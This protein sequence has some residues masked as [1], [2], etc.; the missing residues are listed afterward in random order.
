MHN[1]DI[2]HLYSLALG[3]DVGTQQFGQFGINSIRM[4][5]S[6]G[7]A[8][9]A[10]KSGQIC[11]DLSKLI[12]EE[13]DKTKLKI[14]SDIK[15]VVA[16]PILDRQNGLPLAVISLYNPQQAEGDQ[17][18]DVGQM[19]SHV[20]FTLES[21]QGT[22][23]NSDLMENAF[24]LVNDAVVF[25][26]TN[27]EVTKVNKSAEVIFNQTSQ[28]CVGKSVTDLLKAGKGDALLQPLQELTTKT[29]AMLFNQ[30]LVVQRGVTEGSQEKET[31]L[32]VNFYCSKL[33]DREKRV[34][35]YCLV[36]QPIV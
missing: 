4:K 8:G 32:K 2:D 14:T 10:F 29:H 36:F 21:L 7:V 15:K 18:M 22:L 13:K 5:S 6:L 9:Q 3:E 30:K 25:L 12:A 27:Q 34:F 26:N 24:D 16:V 1:Q 19:F 23:A 20:L 35:A 28:Q 31:S 11:D 33:L 17:L